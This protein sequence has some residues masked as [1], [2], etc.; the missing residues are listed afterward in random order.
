MQADHAVATLTNYVNDRQ[1][2]LMRASAELAKVKDL[3]KS[4]KK[5]GVDL[6]D[7]VSG[8]VALNALLPDDLKLDVLDLKK[9]A[10]AGSGPLDIVRQEETV[11][12][13][14]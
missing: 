7:V 9:F 12:L 11:V 4:L 3:S 13:D 5:V 10:V 6:M 2:R 1:K 14:R 8:A